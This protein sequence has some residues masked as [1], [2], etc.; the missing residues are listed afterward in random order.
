MPIE[1]EHFSGLE[2]QFTAIKMK[3]LRS[4]TI[5]NENRGNSQNGAN[6]LF[7]RAPIAMQPKRFGQNPPVKVLKVMPTYFGQNFS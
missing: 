6:R 4:C 7:S 5:A 1:R 2:T 3:P